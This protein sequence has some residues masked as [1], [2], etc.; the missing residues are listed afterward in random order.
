MRYLKRAVEAW[1]YFFMITSL[2]GLLY[3]GLSAA[4]HGTR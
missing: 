3:I 1:P 2:T 4:L